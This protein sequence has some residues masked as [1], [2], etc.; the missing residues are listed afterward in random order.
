LPATRSDPN[1]QT[2]AIQNPQD[3]AEPQ[4]RLSAFQISE[5]SDAHPRQ[6]RRSDLVGTGLLADRANDAAEVLW[7]AYL[8]SPLELGI[9]RPCRHLP[10]R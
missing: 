10:D 6:P 5:E 4:V 7:R 2:K 1:F 8:R 3:Q 9:L